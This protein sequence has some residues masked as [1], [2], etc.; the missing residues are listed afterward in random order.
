MDIHLTPDQ[1]AFVRIGIE[2]GR[3]RNT[4]N[5][6]Q[7]AL[8]L[9]EERERARAAILMAVDKAEA[10]L[11]NGEGRIITPKSMQ[12]LAKEINQRGRKRLA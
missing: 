8:S 6:V 4:E 12:K 10:S 2:S 11:A 3:Y 5:A 1:E 9:W 7:E